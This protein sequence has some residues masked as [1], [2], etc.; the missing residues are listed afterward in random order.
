MK[1]LFKTMLVISFAGI[2]LSCNRNSDNKK[3]DSSPT[4]AEGTNT[5]DTAATEIHSA[6]PNV[7]FDVVS[8]SHSVK[9]Y[10]KWRLIFDADSSRRRANGL[11][12]IAIERE[13]DKPNNINVVL[14]ASEIEKAKTFT[15]DPELKEVMDKAGVNSKPVVK[16]WKIVRHTPETQGTNV[17]RVEITH[18]VKDFDAWLKVYD[19]EGS[20]TRAAN[21]MVDVAI[22]R[23]MEDANRLLLVFDVT[24]IAK[25]KARLM[26]PALKEILMKASVEG[27]PNI[28]FYNDSS[29]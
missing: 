5:V 27:A 21:G 24:D 28:I 22:G 20:A 6:G 29:K 12:E 4:A 16:Y 9:D 7:P 8:I 1:L 14:M 10:D 23:S 17:T 2:I 26:D 19:A 18:K 3:D 15:M 25:A 13:A 11:S